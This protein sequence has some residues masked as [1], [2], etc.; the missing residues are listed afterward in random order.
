[1]ITG[2]GD[3]LRDIQPEEH[4]ITTSEDGVTLPVPSPS[5]ASPREGIEVM[6][7]LSFSAYL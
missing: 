4:D 6:I 1:M 3:G 2:V 5:V 7:L